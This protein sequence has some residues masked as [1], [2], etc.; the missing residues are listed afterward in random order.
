MRKF[1]MLTLIVVSM[2]TISCG[3]N[4]DDSQTENVR[5]VG[6][7]K[8]VKIERVKDGK[9]IDPRDVKDD[10]CTKYVFTDKVCTYFFINDEEGGKCMS[11]E[12]LYRIENGRIYNRHYF[13]GEYQGENDFGFK[14]IDNDT[15]EFFEDTSD[16]KNGSISTYKRVK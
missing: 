4:S 3:K 2:L 12:I 5:L 1:F 7:W 10:G 16:G 11:I 8:C 14:F 15:F 9:R 13:E 6:T